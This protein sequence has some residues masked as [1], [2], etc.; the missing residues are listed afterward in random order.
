MIDPR[1]GRT[2][3]RCAAGRLWVFLPVEDDGIR[4]CDEHERV[5]ADTPGWI[6]PDDE[7]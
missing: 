1:G 4:L 7:P 5:V 6:V 3:A 2:C